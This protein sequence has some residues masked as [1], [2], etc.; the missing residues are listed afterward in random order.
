MY[1][2]IFSE[3]FWM[4]AIISALIT[5]VT[6]I[7]GAIIVYNYK[8]KTVYKN[9]ED[10]LK[11]QRELSQGKTKEHNALSR[12]HSDILHNMAAVNSE[13]KRT[14]SGVQSILKDL[15]DERARQDLRYER[16]TDEQKDIMGSI[17]NIKVMAEE[18]K[19][20]ANENIEL[21][22]ELERE[23]ERNRERQ[24]TRDRKP[25]RGYSR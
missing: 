18:M 5:A 25:D 16:L 17:E 2:F 21:K 7:I 23:R 8:I 10:I 6:T 19:R 22:R 12:E 11:E 24:Q 13:V 1:D 4:N 9:S 15:T 14:E 20:L 3:E